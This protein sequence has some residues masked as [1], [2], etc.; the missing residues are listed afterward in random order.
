MKMFNKKNQ[1]FGTAG[2]RVAAKRAQKRANVHGRAL[3]SR[4]R[5]SGDCRSFVLFA[6]CRAASAVAVAVGSLKF[7]DGRISCR[8]VQFFFQRR[9][10]CTR[11][12]HFF[13]SLLLCVCVCVSACV[14]RV[15]QQT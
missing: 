11:A 13:E 5:K 12:L 1:Q 8:V 3:L 14:T 2:E 15:S 9:H 10:V 7:K 6:S 4:R